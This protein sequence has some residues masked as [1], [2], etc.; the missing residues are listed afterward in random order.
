M[1][2]LMLISVLFSFVLYGVTTNEFTHALRPVP[3][4]NSFQGTYQILAFND[5]TTRNERIQ[6]ISERLVGS[7]VI[8]NLAVLIGGTA[9]CY[10]LARRTLQPIEE[11]HDSQARFASDA[12]HELRT[13]LTVMQTEIEVGLRDT[14]ATI[15]E[16]KETLKSTLEEVARLRT[17]TERLLLLA[18][19]QE[20]PRDEID[21]ETAAVEAVTHMIP[22]AQTRHIEIDN[23]VGSMKAEGHLESVVDVLGI[24]LD[25][26]IKY[27]PKKSHVV[28]ES[29]QTT[30]AV[31]IR[32]IDQGPGVPA[33][34]QDKIFE[35]FY[36]ADTSR[37]KE[38]VEG[39]GLGLSLAKRLAEQ[40]Q[41]RLSVESDGKKGSVFVLSLPR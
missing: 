5:T 21:V 33:E 8:F 36:R 25:N 37:S 3:G 24:L 17:L 34:E 31:E 10:L 13:P 28:I 4:G 39:H 7:L 41:G 11:A 15:A 26:A 19:Q 20:L 2:L 22:L 23:R 18:S 1:A 12:A 35:R 29:K 9:L 38:N 14:K 16:H 32:V 27:S 30:H 40:M 6:E